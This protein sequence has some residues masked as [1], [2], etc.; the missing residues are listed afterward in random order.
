MR[1]IQRANLPKQVT[2]NGNTYTPSEYFFTANNMTDNIART[3]HL[4]QAIAM[5]EA[6]GK[7]VL[8]VQVLSGRL[9]GRTDLHGNLYKPSEFFFTT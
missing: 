2:I 8:K 7:K 4:T 1:T 6:S 3:A 9:K 5:I